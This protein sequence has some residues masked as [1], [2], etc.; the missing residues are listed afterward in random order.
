MKEKKARYTLS[1][2]KIRLMSTTTGPIEPVPG[3]QHDSGLQEY[4][5]NSTECALRISEFSDKDYNIVQYTLAARAD[6]TLVVDFTQPVLMLFVLMDGNIRYESKYFSVNHALRFQWNVINFP[7][8]NQSLPIKKDTTYSILT[9]QF[10]PRYIHQW[11]E[12]HPTLNH[13]LDCVTRGEM[14]M[15]FT[16]THPPAS[17]RLLSLVNQIVDPTSPLPHRMLCEV[18]VMELLSQAVSILFNDT[19]RPREISD[20]DIERAQE[21]RAYIVEHMGSEITI[22]SLARHVGLNVRKLRITFQYIFGVS[23][24]DYLI[25]ERMER[26]HRLLR[27]RKMNVAEIAFFVGYKSRPN[28]SAAFKKYFGYS[29]IDYQSY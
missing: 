23:V 24:Y 8:L 3:R 15:L 6:F 13:F 18:K 10:T 27:K 9:I 12:I 5:Y 21:A 17:P 29:P 20:R 14:A 2:Q 26:A 7:T 22:P 19:V 25:T 28:F 16:E 11:S 1:L 4:E